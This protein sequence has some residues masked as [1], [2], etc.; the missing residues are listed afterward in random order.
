M[1]QNQIYFYSGEKSQFY[2]I[3]I[4]GINKKKK[5]DCFNSTFA[6]DFI[7]RLENL[8]ID[9]KKSL[10]FIGEISL[11]DKTNQKLFFYF[12]IKQKKLKSENLLV[13]PTTNFYNYSSN[14][15]EFNQYTS[16]INYVANLNEIPTKSKMIWAEITANS[17]INISNNLIDNF[18]VILDYE[19]EE[20]NLSKYKY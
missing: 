5:L 4:I 1:I 6:K 13:L 17:I 15:Y 19:L 3:N 2:N 7:I 16:S 8:S 9:C 12:A 18:D 14:I 20:H 11:K 10:F